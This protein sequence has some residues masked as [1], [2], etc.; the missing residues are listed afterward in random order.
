MS[1]NRK[2]SRGNNA[3]RVFEKQLATVATELVKFDQGLERAADDGWLLSGLTVRSPMRA[4]QGDWLITIRAVI[5]GTPSVAF[6]GS[7]D[8]IGALRAV[9]ARWNNRSLKWRDDEYSR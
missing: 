5:D 7:E 3:S 9:A 6:A 8:L 2:P 1:T 4:E